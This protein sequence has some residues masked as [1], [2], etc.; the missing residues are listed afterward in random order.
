M[1]ALFWVTAA[2]MAASARPR[3]AAAALAV[4][5]PY[6]RLFAITACGTYLARGILASGAG[7]DPDAG[8]CFVANGTPGCDD[9]A[10]C[11]A[12]CAEDP[13]CCNSFWDAICADEAAQLCLDCV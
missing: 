10:C 1:A 12:T 9:S 6:L 5:A 8:G 7:G 3:R 13:F 4:A 2:W 11:E